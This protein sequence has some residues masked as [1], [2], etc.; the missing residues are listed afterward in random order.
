MEKPKHSRGCWL[1]VEMG[2]CGYL[3]AGASIPAATADGGVAANSI[4]GD[5]MAAAGTAS[6]PDAESGAGE[7]EDGREEAESDIGLPAVAGALVSD[8]GPVEDGATLKGADECNEEA[9]SDEPADGE[10]EVN[11]PVDEGAAEWEEPEEGEEHGQSGDS[12]SVDETSL[13]PGV[14][15]HVLVLV[16]PL[17]CK[18]SDRCCKGELADAKQH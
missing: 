5:S 7:P 10:E 17:A 15:A 2:S 9:E 6:N 11:G 12:L 18:T 14:V 3:D 4:T 13:G 16:K 1:A 8:V